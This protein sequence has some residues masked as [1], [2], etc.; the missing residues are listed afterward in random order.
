MAGGITELHLLAK[1]LLGRKCS[2]F[3]PRESPPVLSI[4]QLSLKLCLKLLQ[5]LGKRSCP[6]QVVTTTKKSSCPTFIASTGHHD[7][8][9]TPEQ[10]NK[11]QCTL[12]NMWQ[13]STLKTALA[14]KVWAHTVYT[15]S[16]TTT[17]KA[18]P[19]RGLK[20]KVRKSRDAQSNRQVW[21][22]RT[23]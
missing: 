18:F 22:Q 19:H 21:P 13:S 23:K 8:G 11:G 20:H 1:Q 2:H 5:Q 12:R 10:G 7:P 3:F 9:H 14:P 6:Q 16:T 15:G 17:T 4:S